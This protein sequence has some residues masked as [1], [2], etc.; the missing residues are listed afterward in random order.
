M[1]DLD[2]P[3]ISG[4]STVD[5]GAGWSL[6]AISKRSWCSFPLQERYFAKICVLQAKNCADMSKILRGQVHHFLRAVWL[7]RA[8]F[9]KKRRLS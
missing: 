2:A 4:R 3:I 5:Y 6:E 8:G 9:F 7:V 1:V